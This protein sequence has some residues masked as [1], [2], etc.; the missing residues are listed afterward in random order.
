MKNNF[1]LLLSL[2]L[3]N[4]NFHGTTMRLCSESRTTADWHRDQG[5]FI[6]EQEGK[7]S[8]Q[9][10]Q[11]DRWR[12]L[13]FYLLIHSFHSFPSF[14]PG[15][16]FL[17][18]PPCPCNT[19]SGLKFAHQ[20]SV[21][22]M[23]FF[24]PLLFFQRYS[25]FLFHIYSTKAGSD[26]VSALAKVSINSIYPR[27][28]G[29][30]GPYLYSDSVM[31]DTGINSDG[32]SQRAWWWMVCNQVAYAQIYPGELGFEIFFFVMLNFVVK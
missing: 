21:L 22:L 28:F 15:G 8:V 5:F 20:W 26:L 1:L 30:S 2:R 3:A 24:P 9:G 4:C 13:V 27:Y 7:G 14:L 19:E 29:E 31:Q 23:V 12:F 25:F 17:M 10:W 6:W 11:D 18:L 16:C 32:A